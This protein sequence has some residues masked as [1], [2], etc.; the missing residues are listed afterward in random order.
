M[1]INH[2]HKFVFIHIPKAGGTSISNYC[3]EKIEGSL[4]N[5][6]NNDKIEEINPHIYASDLMCKFDYSNYNSFTVVRNPFDLVVSQYFWSIQNNLPL[7]PDVSDSIDYSFEDFV[8]LVIQP[9]AIRQPMMEFITDEH[10]K[11]LI[12][13]FIRFE[14]MENDLREYFNIIDLNLEYLG[15]HNKSLHVE[16]KEYYNEETYTLINNYFS[17]DIKTFNY[18]F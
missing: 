3:E 14:N 4:R 17:E 6:L 12:K 16:Y 2:K 5:Y 18:K 9:N 11:F 8:K 10:G 7:F 13:N 1:I 15:H